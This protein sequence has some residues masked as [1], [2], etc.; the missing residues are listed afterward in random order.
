MSSSALPDGSRTTGP[1][2]LR[3]GLL[4]ALGHPLRDAV[5]LAVV[6][7]DDRRAAQGRRARSGGAT[8]RALF[9]TF[10]PTWW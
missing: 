4:A 8:R 9:Q 7:E 6:G 5:E 3:L 1:P 10:A 2:S